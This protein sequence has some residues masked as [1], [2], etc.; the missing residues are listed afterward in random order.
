MR[1]KI[2]IVKVENEK[3]K[4]EKVTYINDNG[5]SSKY[6]KGVGDTLEMIYGKP[7]LKKDGLAIYGE[8]STYFKIKRE[9]CN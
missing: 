9:L 8:G 6:F 7:K 4:G 3:I 1:H 2:E 5:A